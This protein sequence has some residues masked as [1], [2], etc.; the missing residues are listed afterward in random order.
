MASRDEVVNLESCMHQIQNENL[1]LQN[2]TYAKY[3]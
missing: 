1:A 3:D 2:A